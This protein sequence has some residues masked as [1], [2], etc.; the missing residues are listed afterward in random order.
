[1][2]QE[3]AIFWIEVDK[4][5]PNPYQPRKEF[6]QERLKELADSIRTYG[7]LQPLVV[8]RKEEYLDDGGVK[9]VYQLIAGERRLRASKLAQVTHVPVI[10]RIGDDNKTIL[11][12]A[13]IENVQR[14]DL[15]VVDRAMSFQ[16][17]QDEFGLSWAEVGKKI[18]KSR[19][20]VSNSVRILTLPKDILDA[21]KEGKISEGH[22]RPLLMLID[23]PAEQMTLFKEMIVRKMSVREAES[24]AR[25]VA[26]EKVRKSKLMQNPEVIDMEEKISQSL[27]TRVNIEQKERGG[28][29]SITYFSYEE[30]MSL[31]L[32]LRKVGESRTH[33]GMFEAVEGADKVTLD[34][35][36]TVGSKNAISDE[37]AKV[38]SEKPTIAMLLTEQDKQDKVLGIDPVNDVK[39]S[40]DNTHALD[41]STPDEVKAVEEIEDDQDLYS[42]STFTI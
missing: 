14:Q 39:D 3:N 33:K 11:E 2:S 17:L 8:T 36:R 18:G 9:V 13:I 19:E 21:L 42:V 16:R 10:V 25:K 6:D 37:V 4:V 30:L 38:N 32:L 40:D 34:I 12:L 27:G 22:T 15:N 7:V 29:I 1:M 5:E 23:R 24:L 28:S 41:D 31:S 20:Y 26:Y 35:L